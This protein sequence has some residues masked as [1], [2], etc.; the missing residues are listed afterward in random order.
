MPRST[1]P[2]KVRWT[3]FARDGFRCRYC[4]DAPPNCIL[5]IDHELAVA[6]GGGEDINNLITACEPCNQGKADV[7]FPGLAEVEEYLEVGDEVVGWLDEA[8]RQEAGVDWSPDEWHLRRTIAYAGTC[9]GAED[10]VRAFAA[11]IRSG[12]IDWHVHTFAKIMGVFECY[13]TDIS[14]Q[15]HPSLEDMTTEEIK[16]QFWGHLEALLA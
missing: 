15:G 2:P 8:F 13:I 1:I 6:R 11:R 5:V 12:Q 3:V 16:A 7:W 9:A 10:V 14:R 4:G